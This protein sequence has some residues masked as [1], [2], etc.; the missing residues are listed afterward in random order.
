MLRGVRVELALLH[1]EVSREA[2]GHWVVCSR[3][4]TQHYERG[5]APYLRYF[6]TSVMLLHCTV[7]KTG[8]HR[9][10]PTNKQCSPESNTV[11]LAL[12]PAFFP[13]PH[14]A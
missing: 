11:A 6:Q 12:K 7:E 2:K 14:L 3:V 10:Y 13:P 5:S 1:P 9:G 8:A 4:T